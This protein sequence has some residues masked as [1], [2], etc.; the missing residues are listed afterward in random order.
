[1][2]KR[3]GNSEPVGLAPTDVSACQQPATVAAAA[4]FSHG[5]FRNYRLRLSDVLL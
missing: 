2:V 3:G 1:M 4:Q 5:E